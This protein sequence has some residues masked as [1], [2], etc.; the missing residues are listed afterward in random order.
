MLPRLPAESFNLV[1]LDPPYGTTDGDWDRAPEWS[2]LGRD[3]ARV[4]KPTGQ[5]GLHGAGAMACQAVSASLGRFVTDSKS[6]G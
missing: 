2:T 5:V 4:L 3:V 6:S 1:Y